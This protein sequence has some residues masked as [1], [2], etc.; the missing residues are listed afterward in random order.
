[1]KKILLALVM[2]CVASGLYAGNLEEQFFDACV[3]GIKNKVPANVAVDANKIY[4]VIYIT[5]PV[6]FSKAEFTPETVEDLKN[7]FIAE[8]SKDNRISGIVKNFKINFVISFITADE[9]IFSIAVSSNDFLFA[10]N[11]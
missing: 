4:R 1:M 5:L 9:H 11:E 10:G 7:M 6:P 3:A 8:W 2:L